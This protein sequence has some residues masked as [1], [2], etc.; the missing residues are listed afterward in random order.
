[1][2]RREN[3]LKRKKQ[4]QSSGRERELYRLTALFV[5]HGSA[6]FAEC[7]ERH[8]K[9]TY[10]FS[11]DPKKRVWGKRRALSEGM[12]AIALHD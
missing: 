5:V 8:R 7:C 3:P 1:M 12:G 11:P 10:P 2:A 9:R 6:S 4:I